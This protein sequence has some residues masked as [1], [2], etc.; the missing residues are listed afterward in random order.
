MFLNLLYVYEY[1]VYM[2]VCSSCVS[3]A[4]RSQKNVSDPLELELTDGYE[5]LCGYWKLNI[6]SLQEQPVLLITESFY[7]PN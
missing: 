2:Y 3:G 6:G 7:S 5:S 1:F 4:C